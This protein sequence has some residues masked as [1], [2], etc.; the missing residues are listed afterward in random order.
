MEVVG[1]DRRFSRSASSGVGFSQ[2]APAWG[3]RLGLPGFSFA[4][5]NV[6]SQKDLSSVPV[7]LLLFALTTFN[8]SFFRKASESTLLPNLAELN[9][10]PEQW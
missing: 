8:L 2:K 10:P 3:D 9:S 4:L 1:P 6:P 5:G 7:L